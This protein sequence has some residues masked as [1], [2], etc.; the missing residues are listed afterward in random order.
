MRG[1]PATPP[2]VVPGGVGKDNVMASLQRVAARCWQLLGI[3]LAAGALVWVIG[4]AAPVVIACLLALLGAATLLPVHTRLRDRGLA[5][6]A[7]A[8]ASV[9]AAIGAILAVITLVTL[10]VVDQVPALLDQLSQALVRLREQFPG[11]PIPENGN[12]DRLLAQA[13]EGAQSGVTAGLATAAT[14]GSALALAVVLVF[15]LL[16]DGSR[17]W[18]WF[19]HLWPRPGRHDVD[20]VGRAAFA[21]ISQYVRGLTLVAFADGLLSLVA[22]MLLGVP[23]ASALGALTFLA[24]YIPVVGATVIG[25][26]AVAIAFA[27]NGLGLALAVLAVYVAIQQL[28]GNVLQPWIMGQRLPLHPAA[29]LVTLTLGGVVAGI[30][31]ALLA[32]PLTAA[33]VAGVSRYQE[34]EQPEVADATQEG[35]LPGVDR[36]REVVGRLG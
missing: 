1:C 18:A 27:S 19:L 15:F 8:A 30:A 13:Q 16:R 12:L 31:G 36:D 5:P 34:L 3:L 14:V 26:L 28:D 10:Q 17:M 32:V 24:A 20:E 21:T 29:V 22:L 7:A 11:I 25:A 33:V 4:R 9:S 2:R 35:A 6:T 23:L